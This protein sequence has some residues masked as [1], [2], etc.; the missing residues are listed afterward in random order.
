MMSMRITGNIT[1]GGKFEVIENWGGG[2]TK[3][4]KSNRTVR[5]VERHF[6]SY[7]MKERVRITANQICR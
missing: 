3:Q 7:I 2:G 4:N 5:A 6:F 1:G